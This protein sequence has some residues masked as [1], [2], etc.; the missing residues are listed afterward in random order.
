MNK[1][2]LNK[3]TWESISQLDLDY[4]QLKKDLAEHADSDE[5]IDAM[6]NYYRL[7]LEMLEEISKELKE[8]KIENEKINI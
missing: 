6:I 1:S 5:V 3:D 2:Q 8:K 4:E 7:K